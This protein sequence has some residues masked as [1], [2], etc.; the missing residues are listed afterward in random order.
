MIPTP[1]SSAPLAERRAGLLLHP[2]SLPGPHGT[3]DLGPWAR[4]FLDWAAGA[5]ATLWQ[6]LPLCPPGGPYADCPYASWSA[7]AGNPALLSLEDLQ[8]DGLLEAGDLAGAFPEGTLDVGD[9]RAWKAARLARAAD[10]LLADPRHPLAPALARF[11]AGAAW[12]EDTALF[13]ALKAHHGGAPWW[14]WERPLRDRAPAA[15]REAHRELAAEVD[16]E[17]ALQ[18]LFERQWAALR[19]HARARGIR[20]L[21]D[22]PIYVL[23]DSA[24]VWAAPAGFRLAEDG[25][26]LAVSGCP[27]DEFTADGQLWGGPIYDWERMA[28]DDF[29]WWRA[30]LARALEHADVVRIDHFRAL[31]AHWEIPAGARTAREGRWV[32]GPGLRLFQ[33]LARHLGPLPL[34]VEDL[35]AIDDEV[36]ALREATGFPGMRI[37]HYAFGG[38]P[39]N[40]HLPHNHPENAIAYPANHDNDTTTGWWST[41]APHTRAHAQLYLGRHGDDIAWDLVRAALASPARTAVV[42]V[43]DLLA[44]GSEAR[45]NEPASYARPMETWRNWRWRLRPEQLDGFA[46][47]RFRQLAAL[48]GRLP[49]GQG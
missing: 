8:A 1:F 19:A 48:Y 14:R 21:G 28:A 5:G 33:A 32:G 46:A 17:V 15:L 3:G 39:D 6:V 29:G 11:R 36:I 22:V 44:L 31:A 13:A 10:R 24:D 49:P 16:R 37:L 35:G 26:L 2:S 27:P 23:H 7:L 12:A 43:Q 34:C 20:V 18:F 30:R 25:T 38:G 47:R 40:P 41:L 9:G 4:R 45:M 42:Q